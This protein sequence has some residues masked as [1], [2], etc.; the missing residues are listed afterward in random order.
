MEVAKEVIRCLAD[1]FRYPPLLFPCALFPAVWVVAVLQTVKQDLVGYLIVELV[2]L[3]VTFFEV[4]NLVLVLSLE[5]SL[6]QT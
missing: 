6:S 4:E 2:L 3:I 1:R 5:G